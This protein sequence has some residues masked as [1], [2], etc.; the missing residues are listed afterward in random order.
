MEVAKG[1]IAHFVPQR[2]LVHSPCAQ[3]NAC[4][5]L[6]SGSSNHRQ[7]QSRLWIGGGAFCSIPGHVLT[8]LP[9]FI[10]HQESGAGAPI[11]EALLRR[12]VSGQLTGGGR[13]L[14]TSFA[15]CNPAEPEE[16]SSILA[17]SH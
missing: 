14:R 1:A 3:Q 10:G 17:A 16:S 7:T 8:A 13:P 15:A 2:A 4:E 6:S 11:W 5:L 9:L 12:H